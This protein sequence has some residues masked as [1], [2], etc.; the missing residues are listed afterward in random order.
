MHIVKTKESMSST[1]LGMLAPSKLRSLGDLIV[2]P[3]EGDLEG[4]QFLNLTHQFAQI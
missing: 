1:I 2:V 3:N 4:T